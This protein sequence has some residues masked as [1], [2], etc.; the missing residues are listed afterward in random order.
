[1][2]H[3]QTYLKCLHLQWNFVHCFVRVLIRKI[4]YFLSLESENK[5]Y[6]LLNSKTLRTDRGLV[7]LTVCKAVQ[8]PA[9]SDEASGKSA[10][11]NVLLK[12]LLAIF[13][14]LKYTHIYESS[15][16]R[17]KSQTSIL[18]SQKPSNQNAITFRQVLILSISLLFFT[19]EYL[20]LS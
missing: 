11:N 19:A 5:P 16:F 17:Q 3:F 1:M 14:F 2:L 18:F 20:M 6:L 12:V 15:I 13:F 7:S 4:K 9:L 10:N 8:R